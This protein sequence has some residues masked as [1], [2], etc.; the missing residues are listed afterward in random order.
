MNTLRILNYDTHAHIDLYKNMRAYVD[1]IEKALCYTIVVTNVPKLY[2]KYIREYE[3]YQYVRFALGLHPE[4]AVQYK[5]QLSIFHDAVKTSRYIGEVGLD[6]TKGIDKEQ[7]KIFEEIM[8]SCQQYGGKIIS[9]HSRRAANNTIDVI[10]KCTNNIIILHWF[11]IL[12]PGSETQI[13]KK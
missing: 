11:S 10:G 13:E 1:V 6:F 9:V 4:L 3:D 5:S 8:K 7:I 12:L 2:K